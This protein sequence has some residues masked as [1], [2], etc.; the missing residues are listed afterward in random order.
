M[1]TSR[2]QTAIEM[3]FILSIIFIGLIL[4]VPSYVE[5]N[6]NVAIVGY[7]RSS[8]SKA[9]DYLNTGIMTNEEPYSYLNPILANITENPRLSIKSLTS[10]ETGSEVTI[11]V[12]LSTPFQSI[13]TLPSLA[14]NITAFVKKDLV[15]NFRFTDN[16]GVLSYGGKTVNI[17]IDVVRG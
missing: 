15:E 5:N 14:E 2:A 11:K 1:R 17:E 6:T 3:V 13:E 4:I 7:V 12:T 9:V 16:N 10:E 8:V